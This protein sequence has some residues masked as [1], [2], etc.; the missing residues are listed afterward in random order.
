MNDKAFASQLQ[1]QLGGSVRVLETGNGILTVEIPVEQWL[2][3]TRTLKDHEAFAFEQ[4]TDL[5]GVDY[6]GHGQTE[7]N[8]EDATGSG[9]SRGVQGLGP[10][11]P[12]LAGLRLG[13][14]LEQG[15]LQ[16]VAVHGVLAC[17]LRFARQDE[18]VLVGPT[19]GCQG[20]RYPVNPA[21][22]HSR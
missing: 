22:V 19:G 8:T 6:L 11:G 12:R 15:V 17:E 14:V 5:C 13:R 20:E 3:A 1:D 16:R 21:A 9:F 10:L 18:G 4:L 2:T 7:W